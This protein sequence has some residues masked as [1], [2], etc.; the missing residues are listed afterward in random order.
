MASK[1]DIRKLSL[2][3]QI[4]AMQN[5]SGVSDEVKKK[6]IANMNRRMTRKMTVLPVEV[7]KLFGA[8]NLSEN[9]D[10]TFDED[11]EDNEDDESTEDSD[12]EERSKEELNDMFSPENMRCLA[13]ISHNYMKPAMKLFVLANKNVLRRFRLT[14]TATT[15]KMLRSVFGDDPNVV[16]G[17]TCSSGPL[18]GDA[19]VAAQMCMEDLG[20][21]F[22]FRDPLTSHPH[23]ADIES[24]A[25][26]ANVHNIMTCEN[27]TTGLMLIN[28][29]KMAT[30]E[31]RPELIPSFFT[32][33]ESPCVKSY[34]EEQNRV[35]AS[36]AGNPIMEARHSSPYARKLKAEVKA[37][38][39]KEVVAVQAAGAA[40]L[41]Q[42]AV[43]NDNPTLQA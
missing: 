5:P 41:S 30:E 28:V 18:G 10:D 38:Q 15:M 37:S 24:L 12:S 22:F 23:I 29:L 17:P 7:A 40:K 36:V 27:P 1:T 19:Q 32:T 2:V 20:G 35:S 34:Q 43:N 9:V 33:L 14:G 42:E 21:M 4:P 39:L 25:R 13:L 6:Q 3:T 16:Y 8:Q 11:D 31:K 26:L